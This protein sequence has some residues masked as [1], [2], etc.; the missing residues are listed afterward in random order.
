MSQELNQQRERLAMEE[1][2][3]EQVRLETESLQKSL[4]LHQAELENR[5]KNLAKTN[6]QHSPDDLERNED[7]IR[8]EVEIFRKIRRSLVEEKQFLEHFLVFLFHYF[9]YTFLKSK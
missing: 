7:D 6:Q 9:P 1:A 8:R 2:R 5:S 4:L 3:L